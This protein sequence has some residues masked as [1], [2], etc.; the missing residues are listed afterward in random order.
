MGSLKHSRVGFDG[1]VVLAKDWPEKWPL[2]LIS[3]PQQSQ[4][5][6]N[7]LLPSSE[8]IHFPP[9]GKWQFLFFRKRTWYTLLYPTL[10]KIHFPLKSSHN[11]MR[12]LYWESKSSTAG[13][14]TGP[15]HCRT[16][17]RG[18]GTTVKPCLTVESSPQA[19]NN[20]GEKL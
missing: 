16:K 6:R 12:I 8:V 17:S 15:E 3:A 1:F 19:S 20:L 14:A 13:R 18:K 11:P 7:Y 4:G 10:R 9:K 2:F 5:Q